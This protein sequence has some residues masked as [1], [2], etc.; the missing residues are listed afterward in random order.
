MRSDLGWGIVGRISLHLDE[1]DTNEDRI[2][3]SYRLYT[4]EVHEPPSTQIEA[5]NLGKACNFVLKTN[6]KEVINPFQ[7]IK[8]FEM[9]FSKKQANKQASMSQDDRSF[10]RRM[11]GGISHT[12]SGHYQ[13]PLPLRDTI[14]RLPDNRA[15]AFRRLL[16]LK[17]RMEYRQDYTA[18]MKDL[19]NKGYAER[20]P[21]G[22]RPR[23]DG[24]QWYIPTMGCITPRSPT[25][26]ESCSIAVRPIWASR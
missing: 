9:D 17:S 2:G 21:Q 16:K 23:R 18:F 11:E 12:P 4:R 22:Q 24:K 5:A 15:F 13:M 14:P 1:E 6:V 3:V 20:V 26:L 19:A 8:M 25:R 7:I 10:L